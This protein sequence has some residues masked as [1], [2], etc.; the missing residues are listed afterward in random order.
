MLNI[1][2]KEVTFCGIIDVDGKSVS[3]YSKR[4]KRIREQTKCSQNDAVN[5]HGTCEDPPFPWLGMRA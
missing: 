5:E 1:K 3:L 2:S 4:I